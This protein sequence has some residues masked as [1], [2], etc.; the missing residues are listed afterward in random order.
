[1]GQQQQRPTVL[2]QQLPQLAEKPPPLSGSKPQALQQKISQG[3][4][5]ARKPPQNASIQPPPES[6][7]AIATMIR[8]SSRKKRPSTAPLKASSVKCD[9]RELIL[10]S[11]PLPN[12]TIVAIHPNI[13]N[14]TQESSEDE[15]RQVNDD[16]EVTENLPPPSFTPPP[17][18]SLLPPYTP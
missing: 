16:V 2:R 11:D 13:L 3:K 9:T 10:K 4:Q 12:E 15:Q 14:I 8:E 5:Q 18:Y 7:S 6:A 1:M 17:R